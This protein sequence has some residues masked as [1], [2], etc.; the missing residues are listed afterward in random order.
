MLTDFNLDKLSHFHPFTITSHPC[1][2]QLSFIIRNLGKHTQALQTQLVVG[3]KVTVDGGYGRI[4]SKKA[5]SATSMVSWRY[6][7]HTFYFLDKGN[8]WPE[9]RG[10]PIFVGRGKFYRLM[11]QKVT[12]LV[13][14]RTFNYTQ[15]SEQDRL[16]AD[17]ISEKLSLPLSMYQVFGCGPTPMLSS[18]KE[19]LVSKVLR[20]LAQ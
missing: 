9:Q 11:V 1:E 7:H 18:L 13:E 17:D 12:D 3:Q 15:D 2:Q 10:S 20:S 14:V 16:S 4:M 19:Q 6:R 8:G 5:K